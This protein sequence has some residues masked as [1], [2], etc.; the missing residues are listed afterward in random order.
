MDN[1][2]RFSSLVLAVIGLLDSIYLTW[3]KYTG[4]YTLCGPIGNCESVNTSRYSEILGIPIAILGAGVYLLIILLLILEVR[5]SIFTEFSNVIV[6]G[7][8]LVGVLYSI[9]LTYIEIAVL[10]AICPYCT[11]SAVVLVVLFILSTIRLLRS[12]D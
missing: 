6:F 12:F 11:I 10:N 5:I 2:L 7:L 4:M 8:S 9:Y 1:K 3:V